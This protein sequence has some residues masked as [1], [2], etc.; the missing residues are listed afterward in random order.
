MSNE[1]VEQELGGC[2]AGAERRRREL[3]ALLLAAA[4]A[5]RANRQHVAI[6]EYVARSVERVSRGRVA[7]LLSAAG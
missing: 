7:T 3:R 1:N 5:A 4:D 6:T 2:G